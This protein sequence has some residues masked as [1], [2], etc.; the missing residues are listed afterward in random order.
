MDILVLLQGKEGP[1]IKG[2]AGRWFLEN[3]E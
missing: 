1:R 2:F 3:L